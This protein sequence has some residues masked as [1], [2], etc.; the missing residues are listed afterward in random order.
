MTI[1]V[2]PIPS[3]IELAAPAFT[4]TTANSAGSAT[5]AVSSNSDL[6]VFDTTVPTS[7]ST[8]TVAASTGTSTVA[9][10]RDHVHG[11][12]GVAVAATEAEMEAASSATLYVSPG[13]TQYHPG[14]AKACCKIA[15]DGASFDA[16]YNISAVHDL[17]TGDRHIHMTTAFSSTDWVPMASCGGDDAATARADEP[18]NADSV[19]VIT[20]RWSGSAMVRYDLTTYFAA[21]GTQ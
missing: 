10:R 11:S 4:L 17:G 3:T 21:F 7:I 12:T 13:R 9:P 1:H 14:V 16:A 6:L 19:N 18:L 5:T 15:S 20:Y 2:T 8:S